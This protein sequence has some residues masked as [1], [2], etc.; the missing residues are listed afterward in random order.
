MSEQTRARTRATRLIA[1]AVLCIGVFAL[2]PSTAST[3]APTRA[4]IRSAEQQLSN[5]ENTQATLDE[6]YNLATYRLQ[7]AQAKLASAQLAASKAAAAHQSAVTE[8][9]QRVRSAYEL[10]PGSELDLLFGAKSLNV[11]SD[12]AQYLN[13]I[14]AGDQNAA[15]RA[16]VSGQRARWAAATLTRAAKARAAAVRTLTSKKAALVNSIAA[17]RSLIDHMKASLRQAIL[18]RR[19]ERRRQEELLRERLAREAAARRA[20]AATPVASAPSAPSSG[21]SGGGFVPPANAS[22]AQIAISAAESQLGVPYVYGASDPGHGFDCSGLTMWAWGQAG[23]S[24]P[25]VAAL[26]Y[27][28]LPHVSRTQLQPGDLVFFYSPIHH[29]GIYVGGGQMIDAP[30]TGAYVERTSVYWAA[31]SGAARP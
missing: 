13:E 23:V 28:D 16:A 22:Q 1:A 25:H 31:Y 10:G 30:H 15:T 14:V 19:A 11:L 6:Q 26:Q 9:S 8:L 3:A 29:V 2:I 12:R 17:Q 20:A 7:Q 5:L 4:E 21:G 27:A 18:A 24:L